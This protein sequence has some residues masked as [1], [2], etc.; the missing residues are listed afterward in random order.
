[1]SVLEIRH[2]GMSGKIR[3][4]SI[5][6]SALGEDQQGGGP[7]N[8]KACGLR[9]VGSIADL[10]PHSDPGPLWIGMYSGEGKSWIKANSTSRASSMPAAGPGNPEN[11]VP[12]LSCRAM[13]WFARLS[14]TGPC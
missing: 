14:A 9:K 4:A 8:S 3:A 7:P 10:R 12:H 2:V 6:A 13:L 11:I 5:E 1:M